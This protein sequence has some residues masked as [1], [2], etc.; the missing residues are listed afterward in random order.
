MK[1]QYGKI[2]TMSKGNI[3]KIRSMIED[4]LFVI[5]EDHGLKF[6][7]GNGSYDSDSV[8]FNGFR[9]SLADSLNPEEKALESVISTHKYAEHLVTLDKS[10]IGT[11]RGQQFQLV[12]YKT[13]ARK[14]P[15]VIQDVKTGQ[16]FVTTEQSVLRM[17]GE[18]K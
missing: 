1:T 13:R 16:R 7:L 4:S 11:E 2:E 6:E 10:K 18:D 12:G 15:F 5:M 3:Q 17:F 14:R 8:K 9:I